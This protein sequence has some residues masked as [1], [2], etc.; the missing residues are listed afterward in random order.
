MGG[1]ETQ[2]QGEQCAFAGT[3]RSHQ[4]HHRPR[5][6]IKVQLLQHRIADGVAKTHPLQPEVTPQLTKIHRIGGIHRLARLPFDLPQT[7]QRRLALLEL[8]EV[9]RDVG[10]W[11]DQNDQARQITAETCDVEVTALNPPGRQAQHREQA[12]HLD[13]SHNGMLQSHKAVGA[14]PGLSVLI[15]FLLKPLLEPWFSRKCPHQREPLNRLTEKT[16]QFTDLFLTAF[17]GH[18]HL[19]PEQADQPNDQRRQQQDRQGQLPV[20]PD[21]GSQ[22]HKKLQDAGD[23]VVDALVQN[24]AD[25]VRI[26]GEAIGEIPGGQLFESTQLNGLQRAEQLPPQPLADPKSRIGQKRV[27]AELG[28]FLNREDQHPL[29]DQLEDTAEILRAERRKQFTGKAHQQREAAHVNHHAQP[30]HQQLTQMRSQQ[31][32]QTPEAGLRRGEHGGTVSMPCRSSA[33]DEA[34]SVPQVEGLGVHRRR[35]QTTNPDGRRSRQRHGGNPSWPAT[36]RGRS[37]CA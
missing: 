15:N 24:F 22:D 14:L 31:W 33:A 6:N 11:I 36:D 28:Q 4:S 27:L 13:D 20:Q 21:H 30:P 32:K 7:P 19:R 37:C 2:Q 10:D 18:H 26:L 25:A 8:V 34:G 17:G 29:A 3:G 1:V 12:D 9:V 23:C 5:R 16:G 35:G